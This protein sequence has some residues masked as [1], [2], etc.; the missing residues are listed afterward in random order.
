MAV[1][2]KARKIRASQQGIKYTNTQRVNR[3]VEE[4]KSEM[5]G[6]RNPV[7]MVGDVGNVTRGC[8]IEKQPTDGKRPGGLCLIRK[9]RDKP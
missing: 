2:K 5:L 9:K 1:S 3:S 4:S 6:K 7:E 8:S